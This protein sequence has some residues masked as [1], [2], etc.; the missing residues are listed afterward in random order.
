MF[1]SFGSLLSFTIRFTVLAI[2]SMQS[3]S[4]SNSLIK[5]LYSSEEEEQERYNE[6][7]SRQRV[8]SSNSRTTI[9]DDEDTTRDKE[10]RLLIVENVDD[11]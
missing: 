11:N 9:N 10:D 1:R 8:N 5:K 3:F 7:R 4:L 2:S 6:T